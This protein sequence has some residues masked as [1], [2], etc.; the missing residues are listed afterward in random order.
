MADELSINYSIDQSTGGA[1]C[2]GEANYQSEDIVAFGNTWTEAKNNVI[3]KARTIKS[4]LPV[5]PPDTIDLD[6]PA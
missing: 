4:L 2:K 6:P 5:P 3:S 1:Q